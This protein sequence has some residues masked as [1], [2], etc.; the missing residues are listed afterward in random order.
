MT[1]PDW[2]LTSIGTA[3][4]TF[5]STRPSETCCFR[6]AIASPVSLG[7]PRGMP[8]TE[9]TRP[10]RVNRS[11][12]HAKLNPSG[13]PAA[14]A[15]LA[16]APSFPPTLSRTIT[17]SSRGRRKGVFAPLPTSSAQVW[18]RGRAGHAALQLMRSSSGSL[19]V[20]GWPRW[21]LLAEWAHGERA[22][23]LRRRGV[24]G[25]RRRGWALGPRGEGGGRGKSG[26]RGRPRGVR[27]AGRD[28]ET[29]RV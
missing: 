14:A 9:V 28:G 8:A 25:G 22:S 29:R 11:W 26:G 18:A 4:W 24:E 12:L 7:G 21:L 3:P 19:R 6:M 5:S 17:P 2:I 20:W 16:A 13:A 23:L 15:V 1:L 27:E 10:T